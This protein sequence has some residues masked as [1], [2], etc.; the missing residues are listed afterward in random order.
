MEEAENW[1]ILRVYLLH[2]NC[3]VRNIW[4]KVQRRRNAQNSMR[5][6]HVRIY[7]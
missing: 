7:G 5:L 6:N 4:Y 2:R 3:I 1:L